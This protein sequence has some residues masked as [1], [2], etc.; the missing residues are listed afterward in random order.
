LADPEP[1]DRHR[2]WNDRVTELSGWIAVAAALALAGVL[3][4]Q[5]L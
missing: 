3:I 4:S 2:R 1:S 5:F